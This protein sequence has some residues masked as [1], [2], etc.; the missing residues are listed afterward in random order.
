MHSLSERTVIAVVAAIQFVHITDFMMVAPLGPDFALALGVPT[1]DIG[2]VAGSYTV[3]AAVSALASAFFLDRF[4]RRIAVALTML[5][6]GLGT[7]AAA[8]AWDLSSLIGARLIA[9]FFSGPATAAAMSIIMDIIPP[10]RRGRAMGA[11]MGAFSLAAVLGVPLGLELSR[12]GGWQM[13]FY[14][15]AALAV[16]VTAAMWYV[17]PPMTAHMQAGARPRLSWGRLFGR[18]DALTAYAMTAVA[19]I[20]AFMVIP[21]IAAFVQFNLGYPRAD[22]SLLYLVGGIVSFF[23]MRLAGHMSDRVGVVPVGIAATGLLLT[24]LYFGFFEAHPVMPVMAIFVL[25]MAA[26]SIRNVASQ[27][28]TSMVPAPH[29][30]AGFMAMKGAVQHL[31]AGIGAVLAAR[32]MHAQT[33]G[34]LVGMPQVAMVAMVLSAVVPFLLWRLSYYVRRS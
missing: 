23:T 4:D 1:S 14:V 16:V 5:G 29:E 8:F 3:A 7:F 27:T 12:W 34:S 2:L 20:A 22:I 11:V 24:V 6:L 32:L 17:L 18:G 25:F 28:I 19:M 31:S 30:R 13:P 33:D 26:M 21:N 9:G 15:V 10:P